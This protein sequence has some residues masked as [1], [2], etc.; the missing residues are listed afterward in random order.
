MHEPVTIVLPLPPN[1]SNLRQ[2]W[3]TKL[4]AKQTYMRAC[5]MAYIVNRRW[6]SW[7]IPPDK[8]RI[9]AHVVLGNRSDIDNLFARL[10]FPLD[11]LVITHI[12]KDDS[13]KH[14]EWAGIPTQEVTRTKPYSLTLTLTPIDP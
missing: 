14:L 1:L 4:K 2:H 7:V 10:K 5:E 3:R 13:P 11:F 9:S 6:V 12:L 8:I